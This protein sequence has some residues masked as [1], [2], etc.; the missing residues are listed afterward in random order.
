MSKRMLTPGTVKI[1]ITINIKKK[2]NLKKS[3]LHKIIKITKINMKTWY[4]MSNMIK[5]MR[6]KHQKIPVDSI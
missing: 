1:E 4:M 6:F 2:E 5:K 3:S